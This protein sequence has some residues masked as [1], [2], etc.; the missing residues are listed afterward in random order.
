MALTRNGR[1]NFH[2][3]GSL[4]GVVSFQ[5]GT[6]VN[7][8]LM[9]RNV[10]GL[11]QTFSAYPNG[12]LAPNAFILPLKSGSIS[13]YTDSQGVITT[14]VTLIPAR[15]MEGSAS[16]TLTVT[17]AQ[18]D[19][20]AA[21]IASGSMSLSTASAILAGAAALD[22]S[23]S[24][25]ITVDDSTLGAIVSS[26]AASAMSISGTGT[27]LTALAF[28][29]A[30]AGGPTALSPEGLANAVWDTILADH[31]TAGTTGAA[32]SDAGSAGNPWSA[33]LADNN[34]ADTFGERVQKLLTTAKFLG[35]K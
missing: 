30:E 33:L 5:A 2:T 27:E 12:A 20:I 24:M 29:E 28:M 23:G 9:N 6:F 31:L 4:T 22:A 13:S 16:L 15:P 11:N 3:P 17:N 7:G 1:A 18:L 10:G 32:L 34:D 35:L 19:Q 25:S 14:S 21:I 8:R 26:V